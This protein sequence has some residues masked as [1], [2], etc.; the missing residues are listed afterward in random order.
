MYQVKKKALLL[1]LISA[2]LSCREKQV[3]QKPA[4]KAE[5]WYAR[6]TALAWQSAKGFLRAVQQN[7]PQAELQKRF[8]EARFA[9][10]KT[11]FLAEY[12]TPF[13]TRFIN[14]APIPEQDVDDR[15]RLT[16]PEGFQVVEPLLFPV[17][18]DRKE[19]QKQASVL[20]SNL[21]HL[22]IRAK[23][24]PLADAQIFD[25]MRLEVFRVITLGLSGFDSAVAQN[26]LP[27]AASALEGLQ[28]VLAFY[29]QQKTDMKRA[30]QQLISSVKILREPVSFNAFNRMVFIKNFANPLSAALMASAKKMKIVPEKENRP[31]KATSQTLFEPGAFNPDFYTAN[32]DAYSSAQKTE[33]GKRL[34]FD[35]VL[36]GTGTRSCASCHQP[37]KAFTDG[38]TLSATL[39]GRARL[40][41]NTPTVINAGLQPML[42]YDMRVAY[43]EDQATDVITNTD[44]MHGSLDKAVAR[45][46]NNPAYSAAFKKAFATSHE[47][48]TEYHLRNALG[49]YIR[50]LSRLNAR[51]D[52]YVR[53]EKSQMNDDE[54]TGFN[55]YMG[56][57]KCGTCHFMPLFNGTVPPNFDKIESEIIGVP[58]QV[59]GKIIDPDKGRYNL[60]KITLHKYAFRTPGIRNIAL[61]APYMHNGAFKTLDEVMDFY[62]KG[63]GKAAEVENMTLPFDELKLTPKE[64]K[65]IIAFLTTLTDV[66]K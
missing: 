21:G 58:A 48:V 57:A 8:K 59:N 36:S 51:F 43:L 29:P 42:F 34:F 17:I 40:R 24:Q 16:Q 30:R 53:G 56:K 54:I 6:N 66:G 45:I 11:E 18:T 46:K 41:R 50:S 37:Q 25:A 9:Y 55:L 3:L 28:E 23:E 63:G 38:E 15:H 64:K 61:T 49:S 10:K 26:S 27:E 22:H 31:L 33:L 65:Q 5:R 39:D 2:M 60:R 32:T 13:T 20:V 1:V 52:R 19:L 7:R 62:N 44:E 4:D 12:F 35:P 14:G 47:P